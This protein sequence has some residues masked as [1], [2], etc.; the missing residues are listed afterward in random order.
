MTVCDKC[1]KPRNVDFGVYPYLVRICHENEDTGGPFHL[2]EYRASHELCE[3]CARDFIAAVAN[4]AR[5]FF[6]WQGES[7]PRRR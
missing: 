1:R 7:A 2:P 5:A 3:T 4:A 6:N